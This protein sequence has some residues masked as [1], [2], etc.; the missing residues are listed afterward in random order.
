MGKAIEY[1]SKGKLLELIR[2]NIETNRLWK[3]DDGLYLACS[4][5]L[6]SV[7][8]A[9]LLSSLGYTFT[10]LHCNFQL[11][12]E[13]SERDEHFVRSLAHRLNVPV[14]VEKFD[15]KLEM[16]LTGKGVQETARNL[17][18]TWFKHVLE[19][20][21]SSKPKWL[22]TA[23]H[24]DDQVE[25]MLMYFFRG[26]GLTG[27]QGMKVKTD[28]IIRP[29]L[30][31]ERVI[32]EK[33][34]NENELNWVE[35]SSNA[36]SDYTRNFFRNNIIPQL[37]EVYP[38]IKSTVINNGKRFQEIEILFQ[39]K[40]NEI[41]KRLLEKR[42]H[43][44][45]I[46]VNKL[47]HVEPIDTIMFEIFSEFGFGS[48]QISEIKKLFDASSG[49][50]ILSSSHRVLRNR[51]WLLIEPIIEAEQSVKLVER[52]LSQLKIEDAL[53]SFREVDADL[54]IPVDSKSAL[55]NLEKLKFPLLIRKW[56]Q[57]DYFYPLGMNKKKKLSRFMTDLKLSLTE[58]E[59]QWVIESDKKIVW[60]VGR[61]IDDR[62]KIDERTT[63]KILITISP[64]SV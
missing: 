57:G 10:I 61:R 30:F 22:L 42:D 36:T 38:S 43:G 6:D 60:V 49:K 33:Y 50:Y 28:F 63:S 1:S 55:L 3:K 9:H 44:F 54:P 56:K 19:K 26:T 41:K 46:P 20:E 48:H 23:H 59:N 7:V 2:L 53:I 15:T 51:N 47:K 62:F 29:L 14:L 24:A 17:R 45:A 39:Q 37:Q 58:K 5:G 13:E 35:D 27:L 8:L 52:S 32:L 25:T 40:V 18:Y 21:E 11:R 4:G 16:E 34:A 12:G 64:L 31:A